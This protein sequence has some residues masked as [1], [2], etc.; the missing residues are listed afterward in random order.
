MDWAAML[1]RM[2]QRYFDR[3]EWKYEITDEDPGEEAGIKTVSMIIHAGFA[4]GY[5]KG[6]K[7]TH[8]LVR[9]SPFNAGDLRQTSF[10]LVEVLPVISPSEIQVNETEIEFEA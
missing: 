8:R 9:Q 7:G 1:V 2:Y 3:Q 6:E 4:Y 5:L 10:A